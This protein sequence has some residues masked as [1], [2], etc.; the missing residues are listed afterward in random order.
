[1]ATTVAGLS[2]GFTPLV[3]HRLAGLGLLRPYSDGMAAI[4]RF[5]LDVP[6]SVLEDLHDRLD[7]M[8][9]PDQ[10]D[11]GGWDHGTELAFLRRLV[12]HWR[13]HF[14]WRVAEERLNSYP[15]FRARIGEDLIHFVH[16]RGSGGNR[17]ALVMTQGWPSSFAEIW[18]VIPLLADDYDLVPRWLRK[19]RREGLGPGSARKGL[20]TGLPARGRGG[21]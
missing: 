1:M 19:R 20:S 5:V 8:V 3:I 13:N 17:L 14:D 4:E 16:V 10:P 15:Q 18:P 12:S 7:R 11:G 21:S 6:A 2:N 9:W